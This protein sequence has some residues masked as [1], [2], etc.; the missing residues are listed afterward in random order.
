MMGLHFKRCKK[1]KFMMEH[2]HEG[3][4][5]REASVV[6]S[7]YGFPQPCEA[8]SGRLYK[9]GSESQNERGITD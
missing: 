1:V 9:W 5:E 6:A 2:H 8:V 7:L 3:P 4:K